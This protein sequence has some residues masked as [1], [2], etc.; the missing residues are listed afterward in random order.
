MSKPKL[1]GKEEEEAAKFYGH[2]SDQLRDAMPSRSDMKKGLADAHEEVRR[3]TTPIIDVRGK[4][5]ML[6]NMGIEAKGGK[7]TRTQ[8]AKAFKIVGRVLGEP[9]NIEYLRRDYNHGT[10]HPERSLEE[11]ER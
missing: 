4:T 7:I 9:T 8:A 10:F 5:K 11:M 1:K 2:L 6:S 3:M